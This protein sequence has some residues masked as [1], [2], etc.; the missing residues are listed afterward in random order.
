MRYN[1]TTATAVS[2][3]GRVLKENAAPA[4]LSS[5]AAAVVVSSR[6]PSTQS[7]NY[8][9]PPPSPK[10]HPSKLSSD[11]QNMCPAPVFDTRNTL[12]INQY[13]SLN[14]SL[15]PPVQQPSKRSSALFKHSCQESM[16][17]FC[18]EYVSLSGQQQIPKRPLRFAKSG[19]YGCEKTLA[20]V[21]RKLTKR[22]WARRGGENVLRKRDSSVTHRKENPLSVISMNLDYIQPESISKRSLK[23]RHSYTESEN[24]VVVE[25]AKK[26][27]VGKSVTHAKENTDTTYGT[28]K[29]FGEETRARLDTKMEAMKGQKRSIIKLEEE[30]Y[31]PLE[32]N[33]LCQVYR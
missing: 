12:F 33:V 23:H 18:K 31:D 7:A 27:E 2:A 17:E 26:K 25:H 32:D 13:S 11:S 5:A 22:K 15:I 14:L 3:A 28:E 9:K 24:Q 1:A 8:R 29:I 30:D 10:F 4:K 20:S 16:M 21:I 6:R 19:D